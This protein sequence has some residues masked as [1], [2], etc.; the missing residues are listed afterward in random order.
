MEVL[1]DF[2][3]DKHSYFE[4]RKPACP[5]KGCD[6][7]VYQV[8]LQAPGLVSDKTK[9]TDKNV[10]QLATDF[11]MSNIKSTK[12]GEN[13]AGYLTRNNKFTEKEYAEAEKYAT[14]KRGVNKDKIKTQVQEQPQEPRPGDAAVWG[15]GKT[16]MNM[17]NI[18]AGQ[19]SKPV[20]PLLGKEAE[21]TSILPNQ[22]G[23]SSGPRIAS[24]FKDPDNLQ[25]KK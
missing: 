15:G 13:Q 6:A 19:F 10:K 18:L 7:E 21:M 16:G 14:R 12:E 25:L 23:I 11:G 1:K 9:A 24:Y 20:G 5:M 3:C 4:S 8:H 2:K 22:A 17:Q